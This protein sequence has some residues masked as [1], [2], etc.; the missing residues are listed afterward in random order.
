M[1]GPT[2]NFWADLTHF[3]LQPELRVS[4]SFGGFEAAGGAQLVRRDGTPAEAEVTAMP[5]DMTLFQSM[6]KA[7]D[8]QLRRGPSCHSPSPILV[9]MENPYREN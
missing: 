6:M 4:C 5:G 2:C 3:S 7:T 8:G 9:Y 1:H